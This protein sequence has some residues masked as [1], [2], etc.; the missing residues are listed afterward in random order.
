MSD[1]SQLR[2]GDAEREAL[3]GELREHMLAGRLAPEEFEER[4]LGSV[5]AR[6]KARSAHRRARGR[7]HSE[8][9]LRR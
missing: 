8:R 5:E 1:P 2:A 9:R 7:R 4:R 3:A 6:L